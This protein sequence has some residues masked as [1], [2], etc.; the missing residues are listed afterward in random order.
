MTWPKIILLAW[1]ALSLLT[2]IATVGKPKKPTTPG[3]ATAVV[4]VLGI[5]AWL[6]VIA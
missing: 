1:Y 6:V 3:I 2:T 5:L 4:V